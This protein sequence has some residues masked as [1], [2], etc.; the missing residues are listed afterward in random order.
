MTDNQDMTQPE[1]STVPA[2]QAATVDDSSK[3]WASLTHISAFSMFVGIPSLI[4]PLIM[5]LIKKDE[6]EFADYHGREA[7]N[8]N[9]SFLLY[10][11]VSAVLIL[12]LVGLVLLP[13]VLLT[14]FILVIVATV[15]ASN[16]EY[17][18]YPLTI[19]FLR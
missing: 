11:A 17:Y 10:T 3:T 19:R 13:A 14:W 8:F 16:G 12:A 9:I 7:V 18:R 1:H 6:S 5:W 4:A 15:K 2:T